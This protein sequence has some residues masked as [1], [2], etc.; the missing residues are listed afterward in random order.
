MNKRTFLKLGSAAAATPFLSPMLAWASKEKLT[1]W[2]G[3]LEY[4]TEQLTSAASTTDVQKFVKDH[5]S[6]KVLGTRHCFN[7]IA[8]VTVNGRIVTHRLEDGQP[9]WIAE[10]RKI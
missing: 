1:N 6:F 10:F 9:S 8:E 5:S 7:D 3:N 4:G 2:A